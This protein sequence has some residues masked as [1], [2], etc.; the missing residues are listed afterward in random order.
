MNEENTNLGKF[1]AFNA[2]IT[3]FVDK[4]TITRSHHFNFTTAMSRT[5]KLDQYEAVRLYWNKADKQIGIEFLKERVDGTLKLIKSG[6][7]GSY[8][9]AKGF[10]IMNGLKPEK[11]AGRYD[12]KKVSLKKLGADRAGFIFVIEPK[13]KEEAAIVE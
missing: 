2:D 10:F 12:Y 11:L 13:S 5:N 7:Y 3:R 8:I 4:I 1:E 9:V 6:K